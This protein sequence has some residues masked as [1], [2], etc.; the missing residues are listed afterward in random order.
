MAKLIYSAITSLDGYV[1][2][3]EGKFDWGEPDEK[4]HQFIN[5]LERPVA[6]HLY[7][8]RMYEVMA[9]WE[10]YPTA[11]ERTPV[12]QGFAE[13]WRAADKVVYSKTLDKVSSARTR[14]E[15]DFVPEAVQRLK[16]TAASDVSVSGPTLAAEA[17]RAG[18]VDEC[19]LFV[20]PIIVGGGTPSLP[21]DVRL[22][23]ERVDERRFESG[24]VHLRYRAS[25]R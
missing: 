18:L 10:T 5:D 17:F 20:A 14:L 19:H 2:D 24:M 6:T 16:E 7:G 8:R 22:E 13:T 12:T 3:N 1:S 21:N 11:A 23:L 9:V 4:M 25:V 15:R